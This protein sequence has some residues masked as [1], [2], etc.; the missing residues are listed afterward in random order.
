MDYSTALRRHEE[1][2]DRQEGLMNPR[3]SG[4]EAVTATTTLRTLHPAR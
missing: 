1:R 3:D 4:S 2:Y